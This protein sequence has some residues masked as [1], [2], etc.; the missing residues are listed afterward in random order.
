[1]SSPDRYALLAGN[2]EFP[3]L[4]LEEATR[5]G[6]SVEELKAELRASP[7]RKR[8]RRASDQETDC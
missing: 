4:V 2:G 8:R 3:L 7:K 1:M 5:R 6:V